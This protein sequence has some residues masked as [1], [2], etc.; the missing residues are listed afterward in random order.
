MMA[1]SRLANEYPEMDHPLLAPYRSPYS[2]SAIAQGLRIQ[3]LYDSLQAVCPDCGNDDAE[4]LNAAVNRDGRPAWV[5]VNEESCE[6]R[7]AARAST[8]AI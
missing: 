7:A 2:E 1:M 3:A 8:A 4:S 6:D 5:C